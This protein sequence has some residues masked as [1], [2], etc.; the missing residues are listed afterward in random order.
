MSPSSRDDRTFHVYYH[1]EFEDNLPSFLSV[2]LP[3]GPDPFLLDL[4]AA[5][6]SKPNASTLVLSEGPTQLLDLGV[7]GE[8]DSALRPWR[9]R[10]VQ[11]VV[12]HPTTVGQAPIGL[13]SPLSSSEKMYWKD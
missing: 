1:D 3:E 13:G 10:R 6:E 9:S 5:G 11:V 12:L 2:A 8:S 4:G 7:A